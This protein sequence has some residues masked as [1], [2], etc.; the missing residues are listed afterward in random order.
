MSFSNIGA[1]NPG[2]Q[3]SPSPMFGDLTGPGVKLGALSLAHKR[4]HQPQPG[5]GAVPEPETHAMRWRAGGD[6][7]DASNAKG[8]LPI[9]RARG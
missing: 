2:G 8:A 1:V 5:T 6:R 7:F 9:K 3:R 4:R